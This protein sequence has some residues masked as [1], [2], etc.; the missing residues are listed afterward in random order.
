MDGTPE[1]GSVRAAE[2]TRA[3][4][5]ERLPK[6]WDSP[7]GR[8]EVEQVLP[9]D[10]STGLRVILRDTGQYPI[11]DNGLCFV[12]PPTQLYRGTTKHRDPGGVLVSLVNDAQTAFLR[13]GHPWNTTTTVFSTTADGRV[14]SEHATYTTARSGA[15]QSSNNSAAT[16]IVGQTVSGNYFI[17]EGFLDFDTSS[18]PDT[19]TI[20]SAVLSLF[21]QSNESTTDFTIEARLKDWGGTLTTADWVAG[22]SLGALTLLATYATSGGWSTVAYNDFTS[23]AAF[24]SNVS[25]TGVTYILLD[26][27]RHAAG[28]TPT[29]L[30]RVWCY[31][32]DQAGTTNDPKLVVNHSAAA[33]SRHHHLLTLGVG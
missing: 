21:G 22:A 23:D 19:D 3:L 13:R 26:S 2:R 20:D 9:L 14:E 31:S 18:I 12:N 33:T 5:R 30:E 17:D 16:M 1:L 27:S 10:Q 4:L 7:L 8:V 28:N 11:D 24:V 29:G 25:K 32:A 15:N 6:E